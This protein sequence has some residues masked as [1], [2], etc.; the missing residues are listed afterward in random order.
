GDLED[1][2]IGDPGHPGETGI[3]SLNSLL[4]Q[5]SSSRGTGDLTGDLFVLDDLTN[6][7]EA[8]NITGSVVIGGD[9]RTISVRRDLEAPIDVAGSVRN[10]TANRDVNGINQPINIG[11][12]LVTFKAKRGPFTADVEIL[13]RLRGKFDMRG[14]ADTA[15]RVVTFDPFAYTTTA[16]YTSGGTLVV[17]DHVRHSRIR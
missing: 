3:G 11:G 5:G 9:A 1:C 13:G 12:D 8:M 10:I 7:L 16:D 6:K 2:T 15:T 17:H 14:S 4:L